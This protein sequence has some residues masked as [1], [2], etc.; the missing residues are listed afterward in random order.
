MPVPHLCASVSLWFQKPNS[1]LQKA[2]VR[3]KSRAMPKP[4]YFSLRSL[5]SL[6]LFVSS[7]VQK[8]FVSFVPLCEIGFRA[9]PA[10]EQRG[11]DAQIDEHSQDVGQRGH[12]RTAGHS[13]VN[14]EFA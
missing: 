6:R 14:L 2:S 9:S 7:A 1:A 13:G 10:L 11:S 12:Q 3:E 4:Q 8:T 5:R